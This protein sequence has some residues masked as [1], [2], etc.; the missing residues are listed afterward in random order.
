[1]CSAVRRHDTPRGPLPGNSTPWER[2]EEGS[3]PCKANRAV[4]KLR[5]FQAAFLRGATADEIRTAALSLP[6]GNGKS[7]L[8]GYLLTR[9]LS[10]SDPLFVAGSESALCAASIEQARIV[11]RFAREALE[12]RGGYRF[13]D[14]V[15]RVGITHK[16]T[17]TKLRVIGSNGKT[18]MGLV[19][20]PWAICDEPGAWE[21]KG[22]ELLNDAIQTALGK[23]FSPMRAVYIG[24]L[25]PARAGWW[26]DLIDDGSR[27][28]VFVQAI[29]GNPER[30]DSWPEIR[31]CNPL[32]AIDPAFRKT[33]LE[34]RD[35]A[36]RD[37][38][39]KARFLSYRLNIPT[40][41]EST[42]LLTVDDWKA[43]SSRPVP[44]RAGRPI[45]GYDLG[46]SRAWS[47]AVALW[48][49]GRVEALA[50]A[51]GIPSI[52]AQEKRDRVPDGTYL[53]LVENGSLSVATGLRVPTPAML[54]SAAVT[55]FGVPERIVCDRF[56]L[57]ELRDAVKGA[58]PLVPRRTQWSFSTFDIGALRKFAKDGPLSVTPSSRPLLAASLAAAKVK[59]D[60]AGSVRMVK[61]GT[62]NTSR[63]DVAAALVLAAGSLRRQLDAPARVPWRHA[64]A[65]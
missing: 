53:K 51:P 27:G 29:R 25:A 1:M 12:P 11:F 50:L 21:A 26:H 16:A 10:P 7:W 41:A 38:R 37:T 42:V 17:N 52:D 8:A 34:E 60:D 58:A 14:S 49:N 61:D 46:H 4:S 36:R 28:S 32:T 35:N 31:R 56:K 2:G 24:T 44:E 43:I 48:R 30:W 13:I 57:A 63:D 5:P 47:A 9:I 15:T 64:L 3:L 23:P 6:R 20:C 33:L 54:H 39:L 40:A 45:F 62:N 65:T 18:A 55:A 22:G 19:G 59:P